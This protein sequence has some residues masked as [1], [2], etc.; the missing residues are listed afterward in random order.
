MGCGERAR[1]EIPPRLDHKQFT[2]TL[3][4][5][6]VEQGKLRLDAKL[7]DYLPDYRKETGGRITIHQLLNHTSGIPSYT[8]RPDL[9][10]ISRASLPVA[11][12]VKRYAAG[13][14]EFESGSKFSYNNSGYFILG[15]IIERV[16]G[17][18]YEQVLRERI[19]DPLGMK[20]TGYDHS[21]RVIPKRAAGYEKALE[22]YANASYIDMSVPFA[23]GSLYSTV[24]DL[25]LWDQALYA[26]KI[27]SAQSKE[28]MFKPGLGNYA[29]GWISVKVPLAPGQPPVP[30]VMHDGGINGFNTLIVRMPESRNLV[31]LLNN[32]GETS[33]NE[34]AQNIAK[35]LSGQTPRMPRRSIAE[36][37]GRTIAERNVQAAVKQYREL[38][39]AQPDAYNF[40]ER[41]LNLLGYHLV[42]LKRLGD[43][44]EIFKLNV[45]MFH[46]GFNTYDSLA[47]AYL[48]NG[49]T[50]LAIENYKKSLALNPENANAAAKLKELGAK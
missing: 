36:T 38:K 33:L 26:D 34:M 17:K 19:L 10:D 22:G 12:F 6:L 27:L 9:A 48:L 44:I 20:N 35:I 2:A 37:L 3:I 18:P 39:A 30:L 23:A 5:Q 50:T 25:Y 13:D 45:E 41:Q 46:T 32:T 11:E 21:D 29:Y 16:T 4:L 7:T 40:D 49:D 42:G 14:L 15:A 31:V 28:L 8:S 47:E 1:H 24:E 43:A